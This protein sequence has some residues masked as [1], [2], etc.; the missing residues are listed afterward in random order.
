VGVDVGGTFT[1]AVA[2]DV[3]T[4]DLVAQALIPTSHGHEDGVSAGVVHVVREIAEHVGPEAVEMV[5][6][7]TT[8]AVNAL[9]EGDV[10]PVGV[11]GMGRQP[12]LRKARQRTCIR[13]VELSSGRDLR[14]VPEFLD[15]TGGVD[16]ATVGAALQRLHAAGA[17]SVAVAEAFAPDDRSNE[18]AVA[19]SAAKLGW[20]A[21]TSA[22][23]TGLYGLEMRTVT[24]CMNACIL[25]IAMRTAELVGAGVE[26][27]G[28]SSPVMV[29]RGDAGATDLD[30]FRRAPARTL[31]SGP[32]ASV[33]G[34]LRTG[35]I[36]D[37]IIVEVG[38]TST[39]VAA[40]KH[41]KPALSY[42]Q[43]ASHA[44]AI[45]ALDVRVMGVA[46]GSMLRARG[47][48][49]YG[50]GPRSAHIAGLPYT[51]FLRPDELCGAEAAEMAPRPGDPAD[52]LVLRLA[53]GR[54]AALTNTCAANAL[55]LV[56]GTDY[57]FGSREAALAGFEVAG[58]R[59]RLP[60]TEVARR[61]LEASSTALGA[62]VRAVAEQYELA[63][64]TAIAVGGGAA[65]G[66]VV[67]TALGLECV[68]PKAA[69]VI[70]SVGDALSLVRAEREW[71]LD[72]PRAAD[73]QALIGEVEREAVGA[74]AAPSSV[75]VNV[76]HVPDRGAVR[77]VAMGSL[78]LRSG[79]GLNAATLEAESL[80]AANLGAAS[81]HDGD[82]GTVEI[83]DACLAYG[84]GSP[85]QIGS[86]WMACSKGRGKERVVVLDRF[87]DVV[88]D[89]RG[90][91][92]V[93]ESDA[94]GLHDKA[95][96]LVERRTP[97]LGA[98]V[99]SPTAWLVQGRHVTELPDI[100]PATVTDA[101]CSA[102]R[103]AGRLAIVVGRP[104]RP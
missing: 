103:D 62:L 35:R 63:R 43:V 64:P 19:E 25:P 13:R 46:G 38:G 40:I 18:R 60:G 31:Y 82:V 27:V 15:V 81:L 10:A 8:Q 48:R 1:K 91:A 20:P 87:G 42:V 6:H 83:G 97:A 96:S 101:L 41:G 45:R 47:R 93:A 99:G 73:V 44:T 51:C 17:R 61:M 77:A 94:A 70:S 84:C 100:Q 74:G 65:L 86:Y 90:E 79:N 92:I 104:A 37:G 26:A 67:T 71:T 9:L 52:Y 85:E 3:R 2:V 89:V 76:I 49:V 78:A 4:G 50:V 5:T 66:R 80:K 32:A 7:S 54:T 88:I 98:L 23:L 75:T 34:A 59:L 72:N 55:G 58:R 30:G 22:E 14:V 56:L 68:V 102:P 29:M 69:E 28:I 95:R 16:A 57:A 12:D 36:D 39:N 53:D 21:T 33:A 11:I 24:A